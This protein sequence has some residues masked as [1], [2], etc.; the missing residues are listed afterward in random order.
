[1]PPTQ[2]HAL[3][4]VPTRA[5]I[6]EMLE[7]DGRTTLLID[8]IPYRLDGDQL[9]RADLIN[10]QALFKALPCRVRR[11]P[12]TGVCQTRFVT[13][14]PASTPAVGSYDESKGWAPWF[15]D[16][17]YTPANAQRLMRLKTLQKKS[18]LAATVEFQKGIYARIKASLP[19]ANRNRVDTFETGAII[20]P[21]MDGSKHYVFTRVDAGS[22]YAAERIA[23]QGLSSPLTLRKAS[24]FPTELVKELE[25]I[26]TGSLNAN[27]MV[28]IHGIETVERA[29]K[30]LNEIAIPIGGHAH[31]PSTLKWLK[32]DTNPGEAVLF[33]HSTRM[34]VSHL[35]SGATT[36]S[37]SR[38]ASPAF[39]QRVAQIFDTLFA[40]QTIKTGLS[41]DLKI[42]KTMDKFQKL[43]PQ[44]LQSQNARNIAFADV[45]TASGRQEVYVSVSGAQGLTGQLPLFSPPFA[46]NGVIING[47]TYFNIDL[48]Q[49][50]SRTSLNVSDE[51]KI[52]AIPHTIKDI[53]SYT[54]AMTSRP[55]SLDSEAKLVSVLREKYP[56]PKMLTSVDVATTMPPCNSCSVVIKE[57]G[58]DGTADALQVLWG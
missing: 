37:R 47:T 53:D 9:R 4:A 28:R 16:N 27:N 39:R 44:D 57:F 54:P 12:D 43:L 50:F 8:D 25:T 7:A 18:H 38:E 56:D 13:R 6:R 31:P 3:A 11:A 19:S 2:S 48:G 41:S 45:M 21:A 34:I 42:N 46:T 1:M 58:Y 20:I 22:F 32:V 15:G 33:D 49:T 55:T 17:V 10:D 51:G 14:S 5:Q 29:M 24:T 36:W 40:E 52:L 26:Y 23:G 35:P 30:T